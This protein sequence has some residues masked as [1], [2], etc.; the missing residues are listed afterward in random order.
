MTQAELN[1]LHEHAMN[2]IQLYASGLCTLPE[3][4]RAIGK[5]KLSRTID[6]TDLL[7]PATG[8]RFPVRPVSL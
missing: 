3:L 4:K 6:L 7:D 1:A 2:I 8:L 5:I